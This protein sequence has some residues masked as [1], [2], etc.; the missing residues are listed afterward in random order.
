GLFKL[1]VSTLTSLDLGL[2][3][4][5][6]VPTPAPALPPVGLPGGIACVNGSLAKRGTP[7]VDQV[8]TV[9]HDIGF[10][11]PYFSV[12]AAPGTC[13]INPL[14]SGKTL[15]DSA[16]GSGLHQVSID[17]SPSTVIPDGLLYTCELSIAD[18]IG[19]GLYAI[20]NSSQSAVDT[21]GAPL[22][23]Y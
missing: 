12:S 8:A 18:G 13:A 22:S 7:T 20:T 9:Q 3:G 19:T 10:D 5:P 1:G 23:V 17:G 2:A 15:S 11:P 6:T 21:G 14:L 4:D 16:D